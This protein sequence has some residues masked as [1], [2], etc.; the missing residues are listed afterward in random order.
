MDLH[1]LKASPFARLTKLLPRIGWGTFLVPRGVTPSRERV[2]GLALVNG[3]DKSAVIHELGQQGADTLD[4]QTLK[5]LGDIASGVESVGFQSGQNLLLDTRILGLLGSRLALGRS[6][7]H[8]L[9]TQSG[10]LLHSLGIG[11]GGDSYIQSINISHC[12][13]LF[14]FIFQGDALP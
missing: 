7:L 13:Y 10:Q 1:H 2:E 14:H 5:Q 6:P 8:I 9:V 11:Q 3:L 4:S 12:I